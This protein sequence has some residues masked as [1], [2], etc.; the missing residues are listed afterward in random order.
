[1][2]G[3]KMNKARSLLRNGN[4]TVEAVSQAA[5]YQNVEHFTRQFKKIY[6]MTPV[7][8]RNMKD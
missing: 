2:T 1:M 6:G 7:E 4:Q 8:Y 3:V 5:G